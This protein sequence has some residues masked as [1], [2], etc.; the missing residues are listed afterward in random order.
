MS[1]REHVRPV[2]G[3]GHRRIRRRGGLVC[4]L[5]AASVLVTQ[6]PSAFADV[7]L[8]Q[9]AGS[10]APGAVT[11]VFASG[12][13][14]SR[15]PRRLAVVIV[16]ADR[17]TPRA[18]CRQIGICGAITTWP[19]RRPYRT[20]G[21]IGFPIRDVTSTVIRAPVVAGRYRLFLAWPSPRGTAAL[22]PFG[23]AAP[24]RGMRT[25]A[26]GVVLTVR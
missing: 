23:L 2:A 22:L 13:D 19:I 6:V 21:T 7:E 14:G 9:S 25:T 20:V 10:V 8:W 15:A 11:R 16:A 26:A 12:S 3:G 4:A 5:F 17:A 24:D 1:D 18:G